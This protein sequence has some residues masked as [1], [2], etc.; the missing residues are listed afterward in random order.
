MLT[1]S[2]ETLMEE[3]SSPIYAFFVPIPDIVYIKGH[4]AHEFK[5]LGKGCKHRVCQFLDTEDAKSTGKLCRHIRKCWGED[6]LNTIGGA[7]SIDATHEG[8]KKYSENRSITD[9]FTKKGKGKV[10]YSTWPHTDMQIQ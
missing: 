1:L 8:V 7:E 3:W 5:C 2:T 9:A 4:R 6:V 10:S